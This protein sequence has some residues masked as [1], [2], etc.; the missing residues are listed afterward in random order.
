MSQLRS[1]QTTKAPLPENFLA[2]GGCF[3]CNTYRVRL[4]EERKKERKKMNNSD[5]R[6][7]ATLK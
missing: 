6:L 7:F 1:K 5:F 2:T 4:V 3:E